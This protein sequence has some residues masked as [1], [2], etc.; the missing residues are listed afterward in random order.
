MTGC[1]P[2]LQTSL[3]VLEDNQGKHAPQVS[4]AELAGQMSHYVVLT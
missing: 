2:Y 4:P 1:N 3:E